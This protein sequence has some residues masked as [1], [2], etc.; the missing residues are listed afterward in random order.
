VSLPAERHPLWER[1]AAPGG[2]RPARR[3]GGA[4]GLERAPRSPAPP[5]PRGKHHVGFAITAAVLLGSML[6][7]IAGLNALVAQQSFRLD[8]VER[9]IASL[10]TMQ[11][12][13]VHERARLSA[14]GR[15]AAWAR[16]MGMRLPDGIRPLHTPGEDQAAPAG[17][18]GASGEEA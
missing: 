14:P 16:R 9:R 10:T 18:A 11:R 17:A 3:P 1:P 13:L 7:G 5:R 2:A 12:E 4:E 15:I 6:L 8:E